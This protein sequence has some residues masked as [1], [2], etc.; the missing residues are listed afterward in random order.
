MNDWVRNP[1]SVYLRYLVNKLNNRRKFTNFDQ[2]YLALV[3]RTSCGPNVRVG[4]DCLI[5]DCQIGAYSYVSHHAEIFL[6]SIGNFCSIGFGC[7]IG[8]GI[9]PTT[10]IS[11]S[12][13]FYSTKKEVGISF[14]T[15]DLLEMNKNISIGNDVW[16][17]AN[18]VVL[19]GVT[20]ATGAVVAA[21]AVVTKDVAPYTIVAGVP[22][23]PKKKRFTDLQI[24]CLLRS[25][26]WNWP[27]EKLMK[28]APEFL[29][30]SDFIENVLMHSENAL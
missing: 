6:T 30:A 8:V 23:T 12:P 18:A 4:H 25:C 29:N 13:V 3:K 20:I 27:Q 7:R 17:G 14:A 24:E 22:A 11:T 5:E 15:K 26:W 10:L 16:V 2:G 21:G 28:H 9:H 1:L 19:D